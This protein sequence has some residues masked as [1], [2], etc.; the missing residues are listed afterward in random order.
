MVYAA[1]RKINFKVNSSE[2]KHLNYRTLRL[3]DF[4]SFSP[5]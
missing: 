5:N 3:G 4:I 2:P 1:I